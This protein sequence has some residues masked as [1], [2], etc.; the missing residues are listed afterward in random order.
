MVA[1]CQRSLGSGGWEVGA[2]ITGEALL[3]PGVAVDV[4]AAELPEARVVPLRELQAAHPF[5]QSRRPAMVR[6]RRLP[7]IAERD[8]RL[9]VHEIGNRHII[10]IAVEGMG[11]D[12]LGRRRDAGGAEHI[13]DQHAFRGRV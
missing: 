7:L 1:S 8:H 2:S 5:R 11:E 4:I 9:A 12:E 10:R 6:G 13:V 3:T